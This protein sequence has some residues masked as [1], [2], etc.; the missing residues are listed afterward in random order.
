MKTATCY[1]RNSDKTAD[2]AEL[3]ILFVVLNSR[4]DIELSIVSRRPAE[5]KM[6]CGARGG[7]L[8]IVAQRVSPRDE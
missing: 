5:G 1:R 3:S 7:W 8:I 2:D 6:F 4:A